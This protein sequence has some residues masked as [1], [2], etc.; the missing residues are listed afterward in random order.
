MRAPVNNVADAPPPYDTIVFDCDSTLSEIEGIDEL[1]GE[2][3][4]AALAKLTN[5]AMVG[6]VPLEDVFGL[7][8]ER[9]RP[10]RAD[11]ERVARLYV[12]RLVEG[13][14]ELVRDLHASK[15][16][17]LIVSGGLLPAVSAVAVHLG[18]AA[19]DTFAVDVT[20]ASDGAFADFER[21][22]PLARSGGKPD[23]IG[24]LVR[25]RN[26]GR[27]ALV[28]DGA[29]DLEAASVVQRFVAFGAV[30]RRAAVF[31]RAAA[32]AMSV[33]ELRLLL[34]APDELAA[35]VR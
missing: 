33:H 8:L 14:P 24:R 29:T 13:M 31:D 23:L 19:D 28:G 2:E 7:R 22:S 25:E 30:E 26:L 10:T 12:A 34:F 20:F 5:R 27:V 15:K 32:H 17:V 3:H 9:V 6:E 21:A 35:L 18:V 4:R 11:L 1:V 16:R